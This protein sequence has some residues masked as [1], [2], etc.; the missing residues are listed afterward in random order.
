MWQKCWYNHGLCPIPVFIKPS[1]TPILPRLHLRG[2]RPPSAR[3]LWTFD[4]SK[5]FRANWVHNDST[6]IPDSLETI[7]E[8]VATQPH[9][10][11]LIFKPPASDKNNHLHTERLPLQL[12]MSVNKHGSAGQKWQY[13]V[14]EVYLVPFKL[15]FRELPYKWRHLVRRG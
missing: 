5:I 9:P 14:C 8:V 6:S 10:S 11:N 4:C 12:L 15:S 7:Y 2:L 1:P 3:S 13:F